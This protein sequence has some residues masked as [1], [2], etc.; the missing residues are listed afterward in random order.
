M[1]TM[2]E[3]RTNTRVDC[4]DGACG[5]SIYLIM[6]PLT[7]QLTHVVVQTGGLFPE[8]R[9]V[10]LSEVVSATAEAIKLRCTKAQLNKMP[11]FRYV[12]YTRMEIPHMHSM[13]LVGWPYVTAMEDETYAVEQMNV[14]PN[15]LAVRR[16][17]RV[18]A[19]DGAVGRVDEFLVDPKSGHITHLVLREGHLWG[20]K[21]ICIP[22]TAIGEMDEDVV[23]IKLSRQEIEA[24]PHIRIRRRTG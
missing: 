1:E 14:P 13:P 19:K 23:H 3:I 9:L 16:G 21:D 2:E 8:D 18:E 7:D 20:Q 12:E 22:V 24:L 11:H 4:S 10:P 6:N 5:H 15:E 17:M